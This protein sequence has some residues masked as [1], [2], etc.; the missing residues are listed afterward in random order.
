MGS[1]SGNK[2]CGNSFSV[3]HPVPSSDVLIAR[4]QPS[5]GWP[6]GPAGLL[7]QHLLLSPPTLAQ[8]SPQVVP[9][10]VN[11]WAGLCITA[12]AVNTHSCLGVLGVGRPAL[13]QAAYIKF[14]NPLPH[15]QRLRGPILYLVCHVDRGTS[16]LANL[17]Q[18]IS[19][20]CYQHPGER[21][22]GARASN[23]HSCPPL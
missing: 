18:S 6:Q 15:N 16:Q 3:S 7:H 10:K 1:P 8:P 17:S 11:R 12:W 9:S 19:R 22:S 21:H 4:P 20:Y 2:T 13:D 23:L 5:S 14:S